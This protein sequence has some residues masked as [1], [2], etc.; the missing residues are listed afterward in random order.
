[1]GACATKFAVLKDTSTAPPPDV[2]CEAEQ[3]EVNLVEEVVVEKDAAPPVD[4]E[5]N[6][7]QSLGNLLQEVKSVQT[8]AFT[9]EY[10]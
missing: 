6:R 4:D 10:F 1:M 7:R 5:A 8:Y 2:K 3:G 9:F